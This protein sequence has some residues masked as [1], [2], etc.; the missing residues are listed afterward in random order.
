VSDGQPSGE[1]PGG[2]LLWVGIDVGSVTVKIAV[3]DPVSHALL[4]ADYARHGARQEH[5]ARRLLQEAHHRYPDQP[6][7]VAVCGSA[8]DHIADT[9]GAFFIQ[10]VVANSIA[11]REF[12]PQSRVAIE[13]GGQ[14]AKVVFFHPDPVSGRLV[15][16]DMRM[17]GSCAGGTGAFIDQM[18]ELL[19]VPTEEFDQL[20]AHGQQVY[21]IS[22]RCGVFAKTDIQPLLNQC[23]AKEDI[24]LSVLH[25]LAKQTIGGLV[26]GMEIRPPIIF[27]GGPLTFNPRLIEVFAERLGLE[28]DDVI[29]PD[30]PEVIVAHGAAL[31]VGTM[32]GDR[33]STYDP[34]RL[35]ELD[36][37][38][39]RRQSV[40]DFESLPFFTDDDER[41]A[42]DARHALTA[43]TPQRYPPG[44]T[45]P[46]YL[47]IDAGSTTSKFVL[48]DE[49]E[50]LVDTFYASNQGDPLRIVQQALIEM[51]DRFSAA[52]VHLEIRAVGTT[53]Y[54][55]QLFARAFKAD[56]HTVETVAHAEAARKVDPRVSFI[57]DIGGQDMKAIKLGGGIVT[58]ITLNEACSAG[59]GSFIET[60][61]RS[62]EF[63]VERIAT[64]AFAAENPSRLGS[65][66]TVF[67]NSS[68]ITEQ[69]NGKTAADIMAGVSRSIIE[70]VFTKVVRV[71]NFDTLGEVVFAQG[72]TF[73][74][75]AVLR[76][77]EQYTGRTVVRPPHPGEMGAIGIALLAR[78]HVVEHE[79]RAGSG[80][81]G[82]FSSSF[83]GLER[84][85][86]FDYE[87]HAAE[88]C[89]FCTNSCSRTRIFFSDGSEYVTGNR[90]ERG[91]IF[92][93]P[94]DAGIK[95][96]L[97]ETN[98]RMKAVPDLM[99]LRSKL[100]FKDYHP[101]PVAPPQGVTIGLP[102]TLEFFNSMPFWTTLLRALGF[103]VRISKLSD[104]KLFEDSLPSVPSDT[105]CFPAKLAHG[106]VRDLIRKKV[107]RVFMPMMVKIPTE[108]RSTKGVHTCAVIQGYPVIINESDEPEARHGVPFD[109][110]IFHWYNNKLRDR[111]VIDYF[112]AQ[113]GLT[114]AQV[115]RA[116]V[117]ADHAVGQMQDELTR[118]G[119]EVLASLEG[120]GD[121]AV[122]LAGRPYHGDALVNHDLSSHFT[123]LG[124]PVLTID[125]LPR[126]NETDLSRV[127]TETVN[128][129][130][131]RM[132][133]AAIYGAR[134]PNLELAQVVSFGCGHDAIIT[135]EMNRLIT[136]I[137]DKQLLVMKLDEGEARGPL[138]I[139][140]KSFVET[141]HARRKRDAENGATPAPRELPPAFEVLFEKKDVPLRTILA[142]NISRGFAEVITAAGKRLG[143]H[144][145]PLPLADSRAIELGKKYL[146][147]DI[148]FPAQINVGEFLALMERGAYRPEEVVFG[149]AK[150]CD[151]CRAG[152]YAAL[153]RKA[154]DD[155]GYADV[156]IMTTGTDTKGMHPGFT[157]GPREQ[158]SVLWG[159]GFM[160]V[161]DDMLRCTRPYE[162]EPGQIDALYAEHWGR[163]LRGLERGNKQALAALEEAVEAFNSTPLVRPA[164]KPRVG[165]IG[166]I[167][168]NYHPTSN[169]EIVRYLEANGMEVV[170]P[171]MVDFFRR[172]LIRIQDGVKRHHIPLPWFES[173]MAGITERLF[174]HVTRSVAGVHQRFRFYEYHRNCHEIRQNIEGF[175]DPTYMVGEGWLIPAEIIELAHHGVKAFV[176]VQPFGCLPNHITGR[177][178]VKTMKRQQPDIQIVSLDYD[179]DTSFANVEN[180]LQMLV[181][182]AKELAR[183]A[184]APPVAAAP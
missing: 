52:E 47:G 146:H 175:I 102:R 149:L 29:V 91:E 143:Y 73:K 12:Y 16:S 156:P 18:A 80:N 125:S 71:P 145:D 39:E 120:T 27:E 177:G 49:Q 86:T 150:N 87:K 139:R 112:T 59:C 17:N 57:L 56:V 108:N 180:R 11:V 24:A 32:F 34:A 122:V 115:K 7:A 124:V 46:V 141:V 77:L 68:V 96:Q 155:A 72:G 15:A 26:Q 110:P 111:Q 5:T 75:D 169:G 133:S 140:V 154:L 55:E 43:F 98:A 106:H 89:P 123:R 40:I 95:A 105:I 41:Q 168:L 42:F 114:R 84:L 36:G 179:P 159:L 62:F 48:L 45:V 100:L 148:C 184:G 157:M 173:F 118:A 90:C 163:V 126:V 14:D 83:I 174:V 28:G 138:N 2:E 61:A 178:L 67:M 30:R 116:L 88:A 129:F 50:E 93:D 9:I 172:D 53:G 130:H 85:D 81:G 183:S 128:P 8:G 79:S 182:G 38:G 33:T 78:R 70:N 161:M 166:E 22:G 101:E 44:T 23:V 20:A 152:Q 131:V 142:P 113:H 31:S 137:S 134:H 144:V 170:L 99:Q 25:A 21:D 165:V 176:I 35:P 147:N 153:A 76:S 151:D 60:F 103:D 74:N 10:E 66:C 158:S 51:R 54:G 104:Y 6:F 160:D 167:L 4:Y 119:A 117:A 171:S 94:K 136:S 127:R 97:R 58:G 13:L 109:K 92:G 3:T 65:R 69:K 162:K 121:F 164:R 37:N 1:Q 135:D 64:E 82:R 181:M 63:P 107:D 19:G 132:Y